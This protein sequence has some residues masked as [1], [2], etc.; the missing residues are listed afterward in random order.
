MINKSNIHILYIYIY[1]YIYISVNSIIE[2]L[3]CD[4]VVWTTPCC[5]VCYRTI[6][7]II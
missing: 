3:V 7:T 5:V 1:I 6:L 2:D 4:V